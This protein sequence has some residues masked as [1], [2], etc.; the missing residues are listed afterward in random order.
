VAVSDK[1]CNCEIDKNLRGS[2]E[3]EKAIAEEKD[4]SEVIVGRTWFG[5]LPK[6]E[7]LRRGRRGEDLFWETGECKLKEG[8][9]D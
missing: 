6:F 9:K 2:K 5:L 3:K 7:K 8:R 4:L 1:T